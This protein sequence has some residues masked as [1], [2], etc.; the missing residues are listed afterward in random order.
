VRDGVALLLGSLMLIAAG[1]AMWGPGHGV[2]AQQTG[3]PLPGQPAPNFT[4]S[5]LDGSTLSL[6]DL[7]EQVVV[8][9]FWASWCPPCEREAPELQA[10]WNEYQGQGVAFVGIV[11]QDQE[12]AV[13]QFIAR[14]GLTYPVGMDVG[15]RIAT[16]YGITG[17]P[18]TFIVGP[19]G[20]VAYVHIGPVTAETLAGELDALLGR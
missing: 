10:V 1:I 16:A 7:Q 19:E 20:R 11:Y 3:R 8:V 18:E 4:L 13:R 5:L 12:A 6:A 2:S 9:N 17:V 14:F 15:D